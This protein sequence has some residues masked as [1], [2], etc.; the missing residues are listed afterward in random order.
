MF[1]FIQQ[2][3][4]SEHTLVSKWQLENVEAVG[5]NGYESGPGSQSWVPTPL[6]ALSPTALFSFSALMNA[7]WKVF[8]GSEI[9]PPKHLTTDTVSCAIIRHLC[10]PHQDV[11]PIRKQGR[12]P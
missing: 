6:P 3:L 4:N 1:I 11:K 5:V 9:P 12:E 2:E 7:Q 8:V 10:F